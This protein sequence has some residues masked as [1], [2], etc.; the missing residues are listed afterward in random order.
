MP[1]SAGDKL[2]PYQ[3]VAMI[4][5]GGMGE[6]YSAH[7][8]RTGRDV[9]I[10]ISAER[11]TERFDREVRAVASLNHPNICTLYDVGPDYLVMELIE[12]ESPKGPLPLEEALRIA[13]QIAAA[14]E[15][16]HEKGVT[17]RDL[18]PGNIKIK[19][20]GTVKVLDFGLAKMASEKVS[21]ASP[22]AS[23]TLSMTATLAGMILGTAAYMAP[24]QA[25]GKP[26][27]K[28]ADIWAFGVVVYE[29]LT[30]ER[31]FQHDDVTETLA[32]VVLKAPDLERAPVEVRRLLKKCLEKDPKK[33]LRD[34][35]DV[36]ELLD[37]AGQGVGQD[38]RQG[39]ALPHRWQPWA[40]LSG[41]LLLALAAAMA[42]I[43]KPSPPPAI[44]RFTIPLGEGQQFTNVGRLNV[45][46]SPDGTEMVYVANQRLYLRTVNELEAR[47]IP[48]TEFAGGVT[49]P[50]FSPDG[51]SLVFWA[52]VERALK[53]IA[54]GGGAPV[55]ICQD[56][57]PFSLT[58][59][60]DGIVFPQQG[61]GILRVSPNGGKAD[62]LVKLNH[63]EL[64]QGPQILPGGQ[65]VLFTLVKGSIM[66]GVAWDNAKIVVQ[67]LKS[68][69]RKTVI[70]SGADARYLPTG[71]LVYALNGVLLARPFD[72][73]RM[74]TTGGPVPVVEGIARTAFGAA[75]FAFSWEPSGHGSLIYVPGPPSGRGADKR[76]LAL[77]DR[78][79]GVEPLKNIPPGAYGFPRVS[80]DGKRVAYQIDADNGSSVWIYELSGA[81]APRR[82]TLQG[83]GTNRYPIWSSDSTR[84]AFQS[85]REGDLGIFWQLADGTGTAERL[86][87]PD[88]GVTHIPDSWSP[89]GQTFSF[90]E[91]KG[92]AG[93]VWTYSLRD[94]KA[95][96]FAEAPGPGLLLG[97]SVFS[98]DGR[99]VAYQAIGSSGAS[100]Y[101]QPFPPAATR[102]QIPQD[103]GVQHPLW[104]PDGKELFYGGAAPG[105]FGSVSVTTQPSLSFGSPVR[106]TESGFNTA[107]PSNVRPYDILPDGK[108]F[109]G[110]VLAGQTQTGTGP[111]QI[112]VVLNWF[113]DVKQR[114][115]VR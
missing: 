81:T 101:V 15:E 61:R 109:L 88:K 108:H 37:S 96:V 95:T 104:S 115:P 18:K 77:V 44:A 51:K 57:A 19:A 17:H 90:T 111:Q 92:D 20:D 16:A 106:A 68:G 105:L 58:W 27:D 32:A 82:L 1:L 10:K 94:R 93:T 50:V 91:E 11:F 47:A 112:Q 25:K 2:G 6:V 99:W 70:D 78:K 40:I 54:I 71:H 36:W 80:R 66:T 97:R 9:A 114:A 38:T 53:R 3:I 4:G 74:E 45:A 86:T 63:D 31:L 34:I 41:V 24:E 84:V 46:I 102:Y 98:P 14:L 23:P 73:R 7:D 87:K 39:M 56:V 64:A 83:T 29:M 89:D 35:G 103:G 62:P 65:A 30:G 60:P 72:L 22:E 8:P 48:G 52:N 43:F 75:Q 107:P 26:V 55:T 79:G 59:G 33:R 69:V 12:G 100:I 67:T 28:R 113:E 49:I 13:R 42:W 85:D 5:R 76:I 21:G 110:V